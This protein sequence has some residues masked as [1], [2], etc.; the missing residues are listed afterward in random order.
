M[1]SRDVDYDAWRFEFLPQILCG[2]PLK[3]LSC[4]R[5]SFPELI[6]SP[7]VANRHPPDTQTK[8]NKTHRKDLTSGSDSDEHMKPI[9]DIMFIILSPQQQFK[10]TYLSKH[11]F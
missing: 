6:T 11:H 10:I 2:V 7:S 9:T 5:L 8:Q 1:G 4:G 3:I